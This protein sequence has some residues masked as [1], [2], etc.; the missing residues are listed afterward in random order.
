MKES[1]YVLVLE[2]LFRRNYDGV[3]L[4]CLLVEKNHEILKEM[5]DKVRG[6][7]LSPKFTT[8]HIIKYGYYQPTIFKDSYSFI[9]KCPA[10]QKFSR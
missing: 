3:H 8:H 4:R 1:S 6:D 7:H 5:H 10:C 9:R 2:V